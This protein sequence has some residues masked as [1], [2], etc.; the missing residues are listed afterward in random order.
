MEKALNVAN[1]IESKTN[2][3]VTN[4]AFELIKKWV[5]DYKREQIIEAI[6]YACRLKVESF[7][8]ING[9][10]LAKYSRKEAE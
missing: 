4:E 2:I 3:K 5:R 7:Y 9:I 1:Y 6:D 8:Y 10:L